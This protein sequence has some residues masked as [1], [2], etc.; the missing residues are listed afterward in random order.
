MARL[1]FVGGSYESQSLD[2]ANERTVNWYPEM[3][4]VAS[5]KAQA[6][7][8]PSPGYLLWHTLPQAN[9]R[10]LFSHRDRFYA[11]A[12]T[13]FYEITVAKV[14]TLRGTVVDSTLP[15][16]WA[17]NGDAGLQ[18]LIGTGGNAY[19]FNTG[20]NAFTTALTGTADVI[21]FCDGYFLALDAATSTLQIS[22]L[23]DG[24]SWDAL[25]VAQ[26]QTASDPWVGMVVAN[27]QVHLS[28]TLT[29]ES[30]Y[31]SG[32]PDF[33]FT[34]VQN[35][36]VQTG[37]ASPYASIALVDDSRI[38]LASNTEGTGMVVRSS[39][40]AP[41]RISTSAVEHAIQHY[42]VT[43]D[44]AAWAYQSGG[45]TFYLLSFPSAR[46]TWVYDTLTQLWHER[47]WWNPE[48]MRFDCVR[49]RCHAMAFG[50]HMVGDRLTGGIYIQ[51]ATY[52]LDLG[53]APLR[54]LRRGP[55]LAN[56][57]QWLYYP[58]VR[59][60]LDSSISTDYAPTPVADRR[61]I[62]P[63]T[64]RLA[65]SDFSGDPQIMLRWSEN[66]RTWSNERW[67]SAGKVGEYGYVATFRQLGRSRNRQF[68]VVCSDPVPLRLIDMQSG[69]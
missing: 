62:G 51:S 7:L 27:R 18:I 3:I 56:D 40:Y 37:V 38:W 1:P 44:A 32:D 49:A 45:H 50:S 17:T 26:R 6:I 23:N 12:G 63:P 14:V 15:V 64:L 43:S 46:I 60:L 47:G 16:T 29:T 4:E 9:V 25:D 66:G 65:L 48:L 55:F 68:E 57:N 11:V 31:N 54:R 67:H 33:P 8:C 69:V 53:D 34:P 58:E 61:L 28:G 30:W 39:G 10:G 59:I 41:T 36:L 2:A 35:S 42:A 24:T 5:S 21:G 22:A 13:G 20:T 52:A 19:C